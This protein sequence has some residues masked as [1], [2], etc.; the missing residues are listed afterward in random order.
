MLDPGQQHS[1]YDLASCELRHC[2]DFFNYQADN[3][4]RA[5]LEL[6]SG[7]KYAGVVVNCI[8]DQHLLDFT[9]YQS[10]SCVL[11]HSLVS[12]VP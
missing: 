10:V 5:A 1:V 8:G 12:V 6:S 11:D 9:A 3:Q 4:R 7:D 2:I